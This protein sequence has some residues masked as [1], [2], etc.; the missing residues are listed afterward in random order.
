ML[1]TI[2]K[3]GRRLWPAI[4]F[5]TWR[6]L[7]IVDFFL[8]GGGTMKKLLTPCSRRP[9]PGSRSYSPRRWLT[10]CSVTWTRLKDEMGKKALSLMT[11]TERQGIR[12]F[13]LIREKG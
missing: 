11:R 10:V 7:K 2:L 8:L 12:C 3:E 9:G 4:M 5:R 6:L 1:E 13:F